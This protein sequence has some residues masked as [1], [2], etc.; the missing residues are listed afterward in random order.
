MIRYECD[1]CGELI[2]D[3]ENMVW[4]DVTY[5]CCANCKEEAGFTD[6]ED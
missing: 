6:E 2:D 3:E 4:V 1:V 5:Q